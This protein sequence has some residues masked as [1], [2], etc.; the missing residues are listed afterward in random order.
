VSAG[1]ELV[2]EIAV[3]ED[4]E[5]L[6]TGGDGVLRSLS[7]GAGITPGLAHLVT[8]S[9]VPLGEMTVVQVYVDGIAAHADVVA[10]DTRSL[11]L[12]DP[13]DETEEG[14]MMIAGSAVIGGDGGFEGILD[15]FGVY[16]RDDGDQPSPDTDIF[17]SAMEQVYGE[18]LVYAEG[19]ESRNV[20][21]SLGIRGDVR[22]DA[23]RLILN[24]GSS[25]LFP[26]FA[27]RSEELQVVASLERLAGSELRFYSGDSEVP[28]VVVSPADLELENADLRFRFAHSLAELQLNDPSGESFL[29]ELDPDVEF[30]GLRLEVLQVGEDPSRIA[31]ESVVAW[32]ENPE[33]PA[34]ILEPAEAPPAEPTAERVTNSE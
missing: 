33:I 26:D 23:G 5:L 7:A 8:V 24:S 9:L 30:N 6:L 2:I 25:V 13:L 12:P 34:S 1:D 21:D 31:V 17:R 14:W 28:L 4:G 22:V 27:F 18:K 10:W 3:T 15:E 16:F 29:I 32:L 11:D 19:F 20:P